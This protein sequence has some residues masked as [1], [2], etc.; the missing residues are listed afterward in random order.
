ML[1]VTVLSWLVPIA[2]VAGGPP[3]LSLPIEGVAASQV[4]ACSS[5][6]AEKLKGK[7]QQLNGQSQPVHFQQ[8][9]KQWHVEFYLADD[10][11][12]SDVDAAVRSCG[13][14][15]ARDRMHLFGHAVLEIN[16]RS[17]SSKELLSE[18]ERMKFVSIVKSETNEKDHRL[19]VT[20]EMPYPT[21][22]E[23]PGSASAKLSNRAR[24]EFASDQFKSDGVATANMLPTY[25]ALSEAVA[26]HNGELK[27]IRWSTEYA[28]RP[29]GAV[30]V[31]EPVRT[32]Q[33]NRTQK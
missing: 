10:V 14:S 8:E 25:K 24:F 9:S 16:T 19:I 4:D 3:W 20:V 26:K 7:I 22:F 31:A 1:A 11:T 2:L 33:T 12:L 13:L 29:V 32:A 6:I 30:A 21:E 23:R 15:I 28:C 17:K 5:S 18:L 27:E